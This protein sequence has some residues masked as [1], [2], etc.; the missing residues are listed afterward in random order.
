M[1]LSSNIDQYRSGNYEQEHIAIIAL[2]VNDQ[3]ST[4]KNEVH[5]ESSYYGFMFDDRT[6]AIRH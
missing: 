1:K 4:D 2:S 6:R 3:L 5:H